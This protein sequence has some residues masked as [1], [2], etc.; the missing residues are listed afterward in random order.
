[1]KKKAEEIKDEDLIE[2]DSLFCE[3]HKQLLIL[4]NGKLYCNQCK[5]YFKHNKEGPSIKIITRA[6]PLREIK[7]PKKVSQNN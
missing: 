4:L 5:K 2:T 6:N 1:M 3:T 7:V